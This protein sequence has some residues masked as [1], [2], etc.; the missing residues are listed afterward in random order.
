MRD[1]DI[2]TTVQQK[3][4]V[5]FDLFHTLTRVESSWLAGPSTA[6]ILG[7]SKEAWNEQVMEKSRDRLTGKIIDPVLIIR[8]M[9][10][11]IDPAIPESFIKKA[12]S[13]RIK[14]FYAAVVN[15]PQETRQVLTNLKSINKKIGLISNADVTEIIGWKRSGIAHLFDSVVFS[16][17]AGCVKPE[18]RIYNI[19][20]EE[21]GVEPGDCLFVGDGGSRELE[22]AKRLGITTVIITG[23]ISELWPDKIE[24]RKQYADYVIERLSE[25]VM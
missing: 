1:N 12:V 17:K 20:M 10:H 3:Q 9:A 6:E 19:S 23:V 18:P 14:R 8:Q 21:L 16:C 7:V 2:I 22:G 5:L 11:L 15:I 25:L 24:E 13:N 4:A